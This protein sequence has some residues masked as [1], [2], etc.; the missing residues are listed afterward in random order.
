MI[1]GPYF[2]KLIAGKNKDAVLISLASSKSNKSSTF[3]SE[4]SVIGR[5]LPSI[6]FFVI[7]KLFNSLLRKL[8][9]NIDD[10]L[11]KNWEQ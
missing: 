9:E 10:F 1:K 11:I 4:V 6:Q 3:D 7:E 8:F 2:E 5:L